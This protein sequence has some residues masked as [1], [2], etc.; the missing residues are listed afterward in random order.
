MNFLPKLKY[1][2]RNLYTGKCNKP[3]CFNEQTVSG[4]CLINYFTNKIIN[5]N[6]RLSE[7]LIK[8]ND[9][10]YIDATDIKGGYFETVVENMYIKVGNNFYRVEGIYYYEDYEIRGTKKINPIQIKYYTELV[11]PAT[12]NIDLEADQRY[13]IKYSKTI[14]CETST[15]GG[16]FRKSTK[17][18]KPTKGS[19]VFKS[20]KVIKS[21]KSKKN[22]RQT[23]RKV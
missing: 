22:K 10:T 11:K 13:T 14:K 6:K 9:D 2:I 3:Q 15:N 7:S 12:E 21:K 4:S 17:T 16:K 8:K 18:S 1:I 20:K 19:K 23:K 5:D